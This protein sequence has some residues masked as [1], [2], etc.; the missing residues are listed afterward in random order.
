MMYFENGRMGIPEPNAM[1]DPM[2]KN[3]LVIHK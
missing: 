2:P 1:L 3:E